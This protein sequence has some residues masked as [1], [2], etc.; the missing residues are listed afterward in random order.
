MATI[1]DIA[2]ADTQLKLRF[3]RQL[4]PKVKA[5]LDDIAL[6]T[7]RAIA[8]GGPGAALTAS[9]RPAEM[10]ETLLAHYNK[11]GKTFSRKLNA[12][13]PT[14]KQLSS[15]ELRAV[16]DTLQTAFSARAAAQ[17]ETILATTKN[18]IARSVRSQIAAAGEEVLDNRILARNVGAQLVGHNGKR[19]VSIAT[20]ETQN[21][22]ETSKEAEAQQLSGTSQQVTKTWVSQ[23]DSK[24]RDSHLSA[25]GQVV[26]INQPFIVQGE[27]LQ[28]PGDP[29]GSP[30]VIIN[31]RCSSVPN[32]DEIISTRG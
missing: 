21:A 5:I 8:Q 23:G 15:A 22:A 20:V 16:Q 24:V 25:D 29:S 28:Y 27:S 14:A 19:A 3:E 7:A 31:C 9:L 30:S 11:V 18:N 4:R 12:S 17:T 1:E 32:R 13:L 26:Q 10:E 6:D 2:A